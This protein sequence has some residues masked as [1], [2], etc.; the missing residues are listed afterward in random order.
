MLSHFDVTPGSKSGA[1]GFIEVSSGNTL[2]FN[3]NVKAGVDTRTGTLLLD[4]KNITIGSG[5]SDSISSAVFATNESDDST[6]TPGT[7]T[8]ALDAGTN[9]VLQANNDITVSSAITANNGSGDGGD[10][11]LKAGRSVL[12]NASITTDNGDLTLTANETTSNGVVDAERE[13][14]A[15]V[16]TLSSAIRYGHGCLYFNHYCGY[17][18]NKPCKWRYYI[19]QR[20]GG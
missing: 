7:I 11:T 3:G 2:S 8:S 14:G 10:L 9:V 4:P 19:K 17:G 20:Y 1:G 18:K 16:I 13:S 5:S 15:A 12:V 6:I